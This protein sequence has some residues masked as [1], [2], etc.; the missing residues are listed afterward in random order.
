M[1]AKEGVVKCEKLGG[2]PTGVTFL[3]F[4]NF[5][6]LSVLLEQMMICS[7][8]S[9]SVDFFLSMSW[10]YFGITQRCCRTILTKK[11][12]V[13]M[14]LCKTLTKNVLLLPVRS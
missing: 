1:N 13:L 9:K 8:S 6:C 12:K 11:V 14:I 4:L 7:L 3:K 10:N 5:S 2:K